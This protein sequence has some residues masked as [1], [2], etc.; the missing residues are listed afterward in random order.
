MHRRERP[1]WAKGARLSQEDI[2]N[3]PKSPPAPI[4]TRR[5]GGNSTKPRDYKWVKALAAEHTANAMIALAECL[6]DPDGKVRIAAAK[7]LLE[8]AWGKSTN[9]PEETPAQTMVLTEPAA[10]H[11]RLIAA[12]IEVSQPTQALPA[13]EDVIDAETSDEPSDE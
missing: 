1:E 3:L 6:A 11:A 7:A 12:V 9:A 8:R 13:H 5:K 10:L 2:D 4:Q